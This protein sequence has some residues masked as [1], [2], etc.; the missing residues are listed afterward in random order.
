MNNNLLHKNI[1]CKKSLDNLEKLVNNLSKDDTLDINYS[2]I[3]YLCIR[4]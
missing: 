2:N 1:H 4:K 3:L